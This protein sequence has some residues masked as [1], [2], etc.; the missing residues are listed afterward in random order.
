NCEILVVDDGSDPE[1]LAKIEELLKHPEMK[2]KARLIKQN[3]SGVCKA[4]NRGIQEAAGEYIQFLDSDDLL[5]PKKIEVQKAV[6]ESD[7][8]LDMCY[9]LNE[10]F[11]EKIG[12]VNLLWNIHSADFH[13]DRFL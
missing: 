9:S 10:F 13:L 7:P 1:P 12:D 3:H 5:H 11:E 4:R 6:L 2:T 8:A